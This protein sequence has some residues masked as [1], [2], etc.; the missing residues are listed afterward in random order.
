MIGYTDGDATSRTIDAEGWLHTGDLGRIDKQGAARD[1]RA[2]E[3]RGHLADRRERVPRRRREAPRQGDARVGARGRGRRSA[4]QRAARMPCR[5]RGRTA[6]RRAAALRRAVDELPPGQR[7]TIVHL[8]DAPLPRTATR[9]VKREEVRAILRRMI[10]AT[11]RPEDGGRGEPG[12]PRDRRREGHRGRGGDDA[13]V[14]AGRARVRLAAAD[15]AARGPR[16]ALRRASIR[17]ACRPAR[18]SPTSRSSCARSTSRAPRLRGR[19]PATPTRPTAPP[20]C[21]PSRFSK[22]ARRSS[23]SSRTSSTAR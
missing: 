6:T 7:P 16:G 8:Y 12:A 1:R 14:A 10:A 11:A 15:G 5:L 23:A 3:G 9:K 18:P 21:C 13:R 19:G 4:R 17:S 22:S 20:S 2:P